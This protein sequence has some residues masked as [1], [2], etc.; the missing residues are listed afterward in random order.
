MKLG[1]PAYMS[2][3]QTEGK[4]ADRRS[5][6]W[7][8]GVV[9]YEMIS[10]R[11]PFPGEA[12]AAVA[13]AIVHTEPEPLSALRT[14]VPLELD[15]ITAKCLA[16]DPAERYQH[17]AD[18]T[19]DLRAAAK[20][21]PILPRV[22]GK[23]PKP[24]AWLMAG[25][26]AASLV[27]ALA[28]WTQ[29]PRNTT[30]PASAS[31]RQITS[32][33][34]T[35]R[36]AAISPDG[37]YFAFVSELGGQPDIWVR[38]VSGG[39]PVQLTRDAAAEEDLVYA[40]DGESIYYTSSGSIWRIGALGGSPSKVVESGRGPSLSADGSRLAFLRGQDILIARSDGSGETNVG[41]ARGF[42]ARA[43]LSPDGRRIAFTEGALLF[44]MIKLYVVDIDGGQPRW[45][46]DISF[47]G[48]TTGP[49]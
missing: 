39:D 48:A 6:I 30:L 8:L 3:E 37:R 26:A 9:L 20:Q 46:S 32:Y 1:T 36:D 49:A 25:A 35:E 16:K 18:L 5:D 4:P 11:V 41:T 44:D 31:I 40:P 42:A 19:T 2:P 7:A 28:T 24:W 45:L 13:Y 33:T 22:K 47:S 12:E 10:G 15:R 43:S 17:A 27:W 14:G 23:P 34:G 29:T 21:P 38:Q